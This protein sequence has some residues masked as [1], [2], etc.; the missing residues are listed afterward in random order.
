[1]LGR[2]ESREAAFQALFALAGNPD[3]DRQA[4]YADVLDEDETASAYMIALIDGVLAHS[5]ELD[6]AIT[7]KLKK[8][9]TLSRLTKPDLIVLRLGLYE[10]QYEPELPAKVAVN[11]AIE[12]AKKYSDESAAR[13]VNGILGHFVS[14]PAEA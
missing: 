3:A 6:A 11:E 4:V 5:A 12:L 14:K 2:H 8:G 13:F 7:G 10:L 1:M 9:W